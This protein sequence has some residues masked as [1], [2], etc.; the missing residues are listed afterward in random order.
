MLEVRPARIDDA[1]AVAVLAGQLGYPTTVAEARTRLA[2]ITGDPDHAALVVEVAG[3]GVIGWLHVFVARRLD[4]DPFAEI[5]GLVVAEGFR[6]RRVGETLTHAAL[7]WA[8]E[9]GCREVRVRSNVVRSDAHRFYQRLGF[10]QI[11][12]QAVFTLQLGS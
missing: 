3:P 8:A 11:K 4:C 10:V 12:A 1:E 2:R 5:S 6:G 7:A 9:L